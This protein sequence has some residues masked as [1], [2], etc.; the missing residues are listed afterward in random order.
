MNNTM[1]TDDLVEE[2]PRGIHTALRDPKN[3]IRLL[4]LEA[5]SDEDDISTSLEAWDKKSA[6]PYNAISYTWGAT[7]GPRT[8]LVNGGPLLVGQ[9]C[10]YA[11]WQARLHFPRSYIWLD[12]ICINQQD[13]AEKMD[14]VSM[15][16]EIYSM[17]ARVL[18]CIG[19]ADAYS[20]IVR[21]VTLNPDAFIQG[22]PESREVENLWD[23]PL[24]ETS[25][26]QLCDDFGQF[27]RRSYFGRVW[28]VQEIVG[29]RDRTDVLCGQ[30]T[31]DWNIL[32][33][34]SRRVMKIHTVLRHPLADV[35]R[36]I[37]RLILLLAFR[38]QDSYQI[39]GYLNNMGMLDCQDVRDRVFGTLVLLDWSRFGHSPPVPDYRLTPLQV[40]FQ[41]LDKLN[42]L[43]VWTA[44]LIVRNL[45]LSTKPELPHTKQSRSPDNTESES[46][47][48]FARRWHAYI[49]ELYIVHQ[50]L[51]GRMYVNHH[52]A[53]LPDAASAF[54]CLSETEPE[55]LSAHNI[56]RIFI[57]DNGARWRVLESAMETSSSQ[58]ARVISS[59]VLTTTVSPLKSWVG[60]MYPTSTDSQY[61]KNQGVNAGR[62]ADQKS[63]S[64]AP[65]KSPWS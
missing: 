27:S 7:E 21:R 26:V 41:L 29:G 37:Q 12:A 48:G 13:L 43:D 34:L 14:Q 10:H 31:I 15:M 23:P 18:A 51:A 55:I 25:L 63:M 59:Y 47:L 54:P 56:T 6:P 1:T 9:N 36:P 32:E 62:N 16:G 4:H 46:R 24:D 44:T 28:I 49:D 19:P 39:K 3:Q 57:G 60:R 52:R 45:E 65:W 64:K 8:I 61:W 58:V 11:L 42:E 33:Q 22:L 38:S 40:G 17:A 20:E 5:G 53:D 35:D 2:I 50:D 30:E